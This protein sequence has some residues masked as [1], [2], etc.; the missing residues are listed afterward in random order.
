[1]NILIFILGV[2]VGWFLTSKWFYNIL[3]KHP[4]RLQQ[5]MPTSHN[6]GVVLNESD[7]SDKPEHEVYIEYEDNRYYAYSC[8]RNT[9]ECMDKT[10]DGLHTKLCEKYPS[11]QIIVVNEK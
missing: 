11:Y 6:S 5:F 8:A 1:M 3:T 4:E 2:L 9:F 7:N 10:L